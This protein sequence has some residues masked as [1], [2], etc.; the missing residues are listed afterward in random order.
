MGK[1]SYF[2]KDSDTYQVLFTGLK[3]EVKALISE[4]LFSS[5]QIKT[6]S[7]QNFKGEP[8]HPAVPLPNWSYSTLESIPFNVAPPAVPNTETDILL[9]VKGSD[10]LFK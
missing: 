2:L 9:P 8:E 5:T 3:E 1:R 4:A 10:L 7:T 6:T